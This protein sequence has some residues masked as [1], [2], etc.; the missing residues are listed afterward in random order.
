[1]NKIPVF[2]IAASLGAYAFAGGKTG[3]MTAPSA[4]TTDRAM[5]APVRIATDQTQQ[6]LK[7]LRSELKV[8]E[9]KL[10]ELQQQEAQVRQTMIRL[11]EAIRTLEEEQANS[12]G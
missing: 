6:R 5:G 4:L 1:M 8:A 11:R 12:G 10:L 3:P 7:T 9:E 2:L